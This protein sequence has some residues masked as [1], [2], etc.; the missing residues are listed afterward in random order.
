MI[1]SI[2]AS[3]IRA[4]AIVENMLSFSRKGGYRFERENLVMLLDK[5]I[6]L[7]SNDYDLKKK[8]DFR[9]IQIH[10]EYQTDMP[11]IPCEA[12]KIQQVFLNLLQNGAQAMAG[13][14]RDDEKRTPRFVLRIGIEENSARIEIEDNG[15]G[16]D[17]PLRKRAFEP[18]FTTKE[19]GKGTG[20]GLSVS[21]FIITENHG[22]K[23][24]VVSSAGNGAQF[25]IHLPLERSEP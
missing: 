24:S 25:I 23:M 4:A 15:P 12:A 16:M 2:M 20:L 5:T 7:A 9:G 1:E 3:G 8:F 11:L 17:E 14:A 21:Y 22:G 18:F 6:E 19:V 13:F 10:R